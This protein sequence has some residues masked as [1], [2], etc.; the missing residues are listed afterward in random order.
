MRRVLALASVLTVALLLPGRALASVDCVCGAPQPSPFGGWEAL[1]ESTDPQLLVERLVDPSTLETSDPYAVRGVPP[2]TPAPHV[3]WCVHADDPRCS[4]LQHEDEPRPRL[5]AAGPS[6]LLVLPGGL[7]GLE[8]VQVEAAASA[9]FGRT[10]RDT[11]D[12]HAD[13][14]DRPPRA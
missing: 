8:W 3:L 14:L 1:L 5:G 13:G 6:F 4:P 7:V 10:S 9:F 2:A 11:G 12:P